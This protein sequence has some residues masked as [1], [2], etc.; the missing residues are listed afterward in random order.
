MRKT[1]LELTAA[2]LLSACGAFAAGELLRDFRPLPVDMPA[3]DP[4]PAPNTVDIYLD[5]VIYTDRDRDGQGLVVINPPA[6]LLGK[7]LEGHKVRLWMEDAQKRPAG[8]V[9]E[10]AVTDTD[11]FAFDLDMPQ[12][13]LGASTLTAAL[14]DPQGKEVLRGSKSFTK[15][16]DNRPAPP[17]TADVPL[18]LFRDAGLV[19]M[20][21]LPVSTGIP[22]PD[23]MLDDPAQVAL[24]ENGVE[25]PCQTTARARWTKKGTVKWLGLDFLAGYVNGEPKQYVLQIGKTPKA[26]PAQP[27]T[28]DRS[29][30]AF[31]LSNGAL[32]VT[33][34]R[35]KFRLFDK[36][37]LDRN[38][39]GR[40]DGD[41][42]DGGETLIRA[43]TEDGPYWLNAAGK[44]YRACMDPAPDVR[45]EEAG[46]LRATL[47]ADGWLT[48]AD[49]EK[50][51][52]FTSRI[53]LCTG[54]TQ[55][56]VDQ[57][58]L[59]TWDTLDRN[60]RVRDMGL[61]VTPV[62]LQ[63][64]QLALYTPAVDLPEQGTFYKLAD[65]WNRVLTGEAPSGKILN[66]GGGETMRYDRVNFL[67][68]RIPLVFG[69]FGPNGGV[70]LS[71]RYM[72]EKFPK[73]IEVGRNTLTWHAWPLHGTETWTTGTDL[74]D[75]VN[76]RW[77]HQGKLLDFQIPK[78]YFKAIE[79]L[80][81]TAPGTRVTMITYPDRK[82]Y[83]A[84]TAITG[85]LMYYFTP[86]TKDINAFNAQAMPA[87][88][89]FDAA[90]HAVPDPQWTAA[91]KVLEFVVPPMPQYPNIEKGLSKYFDTTMAIIEDGR[92]FGQF[93]WP[94]GHDYY[95]PGWD[96]QS[97]HR[98]RVNAHHGTEL[99]GWILYLRSG[100]K[101]YWHHARAFS[102]YV[103]DHAS[104]NWD[105][106]DPKTDR[107][108]KAVG[109]PGSTYHCQGYVPWSAGEPE[110]M[111]HMSPQWHSVLY[112]F[113]TGDSQALD[114]AKSTATSV[115]KDVRV[116]TN[117]DVRGP[118]QGL[119]NR[120]PICGWAMVTNLYAD[121]LDPRLLRPVQDIGRQIFNGKPIEFDGA[122]PHGQSGRWWW[123]TYNQQWRDPAAI[124]AVAAL[125][126]NGEISFA[127]Y[128]V[129]RAEVTG[130]TTGLYAFW[131]ETMGCAPLRQ[132]AL[133]H[134]ERFVNREPVS[135][136]VQF[137]L[138]LVGAM[139]KLGLPEAPCLV[140]AG[141][142]SKSTVLF[143]KDTDR[144]FTLRFWGPVYEGPEDVKK[145]K[146]VPYTLEGP[147]GKVLLQGEIN[148]KALGNAPHK[149]IEVKVPADGRTGQYTLRLADTG[150]Y[151]RLVAPLSDLPKEVYVVPGGRNLTGTSFYWRTAPGETQR[152]LTPLLRYGENY[153][154]LFRLETP[155][156]Y[157]VHESANTLPIRF[158]VRPDTA[159]RLHICVAGQ[160]SWAWRFKGIWPAG[161]NLSP[162]PDMVLSFDES[163]WFRP[164]ST[165]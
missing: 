61:A 133:G 26:R 130:D 39:D 94:N 65:R 6:L 85:E 163:R 30:E 145:Y 51:G 83:G 60:M 134:P 129:N 28:V 107:K 27:V 142:D 67:N 125:S 37:L 143:L 92:E 49:G 2:L 149:G 148:R 41:A 160:S 93:V 99:L 11:H 73:E 21:G 138:P 109:W 122:P 71:Q 16:K 97:L 106:C 58:Y 62:G 102:R 48:A 157:P 151:T 110:L 104:I 10:A 64:A 131:L 124:Q 155:E 32:Q 150:M 69:A 24:L 111:G 46:A 91:S 113:M 132:F 59:I 38:R 40:F 68:S 63:K 108:P 135:D 158:N 140:P 34:G 3:Q 22:L 42:I 78:E 127:A 105:P 56:R 153:S 54:Q 5:R 137:L 35:K 12:A 25:A 45:I 164:V 128:M 141:F 103:M 161:A 77:L 162:G 66:A 50:A 156:G 89:A 80:R 13:P 100:E 4:D 19:H 139:A 112:Y 74:S 118:Y 121:L 1:T 96:F 18:L 126:P 84:G 144:P 165:R 76:M 53:T 136:N 23:G 43:G 116:A 20:S 9:M 17:K 95:S 117:F 8:A 75:I 120:N 88:A 31:V 44:V 154:T 29:P 81:A 70:A 33:V 14:L 57:T 98:S 55:A 147:D 7:K 15:E 47:R 159:Y 82:Y 101:K 72:A 146:P 90:P 114:L 115:L 52:R 123:Y 152:A 36:V 119:L 87:A 79:D 86:E